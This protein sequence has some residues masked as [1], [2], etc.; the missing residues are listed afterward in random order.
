MT[1]CHQLP[2]YNGDANK[3]STVAEMGDRLATIDIGRKKGAAVPLFG[4]SCT[5]S[6]T[7]WP[8]SRSTSVPSGILIHSAVW[9]QHGP[10]IEGAVPLWGGEL[11]PHLTQCRL[12]RRLPPISSGIFIRPAVWPQQTWGENLEVLILGG[13]AGCPFNT[14]WPGP[15]PTSTPSFILIHPTILATIHKCRRQD[16]HTERQTERQTDR[17]RSDSIGRTVLHTVPN[18]MD[19]IQI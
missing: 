19:T 13:V 8:G 5:P 9:S 11:G 3:S 18:K 7:M 17:Q 15:R 12:R 6:N 2:G 1:N 4:G 16:R 14:M 10:K